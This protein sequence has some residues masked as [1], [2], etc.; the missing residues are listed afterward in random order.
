MSILLYC[1]TETSTLP[2][3]GSGV[4]GLPV[5][6]LEYEALAG[7][8]SQG[9]SAPSFT[10]API[11]EYARQFHQVLHRIFESRAII[12]FRFPTLMRDAEELTRHM[13]SNAPEYLRQLQKF[14]N[15]VQ[16]DISVTFSDSLR[17]TS[18]TSGTEYLRG[19]K[20]ESDELGKLAE[21]LHTKL[22]STTRDWRTRPV[23][24]GL[25]VFALLDRESVVV[26]KGSLQNFA[27]PP[28][29]SV[30]V[31]GPWPVTEFLEQPA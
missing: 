8:F 20:E 16:M 3:F 4:D 17:V 9:F 31:T 5:L 30:R 6:S 15:A 10:G 11:K 27:V 1:I 14:G 13:R 22:G 7:V 18:R 26:F 28:S 2:Q 29:V 21:V 23:L 25:R 12:P 24:N 19:R